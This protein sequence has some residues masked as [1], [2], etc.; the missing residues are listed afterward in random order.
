MDVRGYSTG[1]MVADLK[2][3]GMTAQDSKRLKTS[4]SCSAQTLMARPKILSGRAALPELTVKGGLSHVARG[5]M[6]NLFI[7]QG[8]GLH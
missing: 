8:S 1:M 6:Q 7:Y 4:A 5:H 3:A 2:H